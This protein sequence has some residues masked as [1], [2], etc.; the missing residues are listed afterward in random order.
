[1]CPWSMLSYKVSIN[2]SSKF[3][4]MQKTIELHLIHKEI[5]QMVSC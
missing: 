4:E 3:I 2:I 5:Q 1:M